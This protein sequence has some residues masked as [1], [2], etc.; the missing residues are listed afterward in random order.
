M[1]RS[2]NDSAEA[3]RVMLLVSRS[4]LA[5][6]LLDV[7]AGHASDADEALDAAF[8]VCATAIRLD[9]GDASPPRTPLSEIAR[10]HVDHLADRFAARRP[11]L[12]RRKAPRAGGPRPTLGVE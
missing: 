11:D 2:T 1:A 3:E 12:A 9:L 4:P 10:L 7:L 6:R 8:L 5:Q